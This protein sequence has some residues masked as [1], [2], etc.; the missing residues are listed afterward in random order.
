MDVRRIFLSEFMFW[1]IFA[2][3]GVYFLLPLRQSLRFGSDLVGG[4]Y[5]TLDVHTQEA[6]NAKLIGN[7]QSIESKFKQ[8]NKDL[9]TEKSVKN[10]IMALTFA[11]PAQAQDA[12]ARKMI[13]TSETG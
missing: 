9:P 7:M 6:V 1:L 10:G 13:I 2:A 5:L 8:L 4:T 3:V 12:A 11:T